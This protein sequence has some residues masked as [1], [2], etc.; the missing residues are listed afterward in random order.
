[1]PVTRRALAIT[2]S[3]DSRLG[4]SV[5]ISYSGRFSGGESRFDEQS[6]SIIK[7]LN[8]SLSLSFLLGPH[9]IV[10]GAVQHYYNDRNEG[11]QRN[12]CFVNMGLSY[13]AKRM[14]Y[15]LSANNLLNTPTYSTASFSANTIY[16]T[17]YALRPISVLLS[18][19]FSLR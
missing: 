4:Q 11:A 5:L 6:T 12:L 10:K 8:Q 3:V 15:T 1:M 19:K 17:S 18:V 9:L 14:E 7:T 16:S 2:W 13:V